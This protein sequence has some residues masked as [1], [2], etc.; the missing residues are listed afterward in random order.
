M[1]T[2]AIFSTYPPFEGFGGPARVFHQRQ[3]LEAA[4]HRVVHVV[5]QHSP[6]PY[7][8]RDGDLV[9]LVER[10]HGSPL[11]HVYIDVDLG[12]R[13]AA[14]ASLVRRIERHLAGLGVSVVILEQPFLIDVVAPVVS[15][16]S[17]PMIYSCQN[18]EFR[19]RRDLED[20]Q[21]LATRRNDRSNEV[22]VLEERAV[23]L[24]AH[25]T[26]ICQEDRAGVRQEFGRESS[27]VP[28]GTS[29]V[30]VSTFDQRIG[31][32][33]PVDFAVAGSSYWPNVDGFAQIAQPSLAFLP[34]T[35]RIHVMG[36]MSNGLLDHP[37][38]ALRYS[39]N[40][41]RLVLRGFQPM[42]ALVATFAAARRVLVPVFVGEGSNLKS[43]DALGSGMPVIMTRRAT[44]GYEEILAAD[45]EGVTVVDDAVEFR[46]AMAHAMNSDRPARPVGERRRAMLSWSARLQP[47]V[48]LV[49]SLVAEPARR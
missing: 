8:R 36:T 30:N 24:A 42:P 40:A 16:L 6:T 18:I 46:A 29:V 27:I 37:K 31:S 32:P 9:E 34:P 20:F 47:L 22:R 5:V 21:F 28:N 17:V 13:A 41:S 3:V 45:A 39:A 11:D 1:A 35:A 14:N 19:L 49:N 38:L 10:P 43:A 33:D 48:E 44:H 7:S 12:Y 15:A 2:I 4:G 23:E 26:T 25:I